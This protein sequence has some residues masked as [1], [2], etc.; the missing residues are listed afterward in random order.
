MR[1]NFPVFIVATIY[2]RNVPP[3]L[4]TSTSTLLRLPAIKWSLLSP[5]VG[6][7]CMV[8]L[9]KLHSWQT[10]LKN[11]ASTS[12]IYIFELCFMLCTYIQYEWIIRYLQASSYFSCKKSMLGWFFS[13]LFWIGILA[14]LCFLPKSLHFTVRSL[15]YIHRPARLTLAMSVKKPF[16][17]FFYLFSTLFKNCILSTKAAYQAITKKI[18][19]RI[20]NAHTVLKR[21][22]KVISNSSSVQS[23]N[24]YF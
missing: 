23:S 2:F 16:F 17:F 7:S 11:R 12:H 21:W 18:S 20:S 8:S 4:R 10:N 19:R 1:F 5:D 13:S 24:S 15:L 6:R 14:F 22:L 3:L 9:I